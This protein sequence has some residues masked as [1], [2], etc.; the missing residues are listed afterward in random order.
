M[1]LSYDSLETKLCSSWTWCWKQPNFVLRQWLGAVRLTLPSLVGSTCLSTN[2]Q[3]EIARKEGGTVGPGDVF[4]PV[5]SSGLGVDGNKQLETGL[6]VYMS[7]LKPRERTILEA[8]S[9]SHRCAICKADSKGW[10]SNRSKW[11]DLEFR[12]LET[13]TGWARGGDVGISAGGGVFFSFSAS[14]LI[15]VAVVTVAMFPWRCFR[16]LMCSEW[17]LRSRSPFGD[18]GWLHGFSVGGGYLLHRANRVCCLLYFFYIWHFISF[19]CKYQ[20][21]VGDVVYEKHQTWRI[22]LHHQPPLCHYVFS[23]F[24]NI[25]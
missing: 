3:A 17:L 16:C 5:T 9:E 14:T 15:S 10:M 2:V 12:W 21:T 24:I 13:C 18:G 1:F 20:S 11:K 22:H 19:Y 7:G 8:P 25:A 4:S 6:L 23:M